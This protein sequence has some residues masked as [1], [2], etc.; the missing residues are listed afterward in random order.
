M[1]LPHGLYDK[2]VT[3]SVAQL[4]ASLPDSSGH[5]CSILPLEEV[6]ERIAN[7][8]ARQV[9]RL[10]DELGGQGAEKAKRQLDLVNALDE[11]KVGNPRHIEML[12]N[13]HLLRLAVIR[14]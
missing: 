9:T 5:T 11:L 13:L 14:P 12:L 7:A 2:L 8:L 6:S 1:Q 4:I 3:E 10:L